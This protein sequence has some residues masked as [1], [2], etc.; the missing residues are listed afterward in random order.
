VKSG[1]QNAVADMLGKA[2]ERRGNVW[3]E[4]P[5]LAVIVLRGGRPALDIVPVDR[6]TWEQARPPRVL[7][8]IG[9]MIRIIEKHSRPR[10]WE[11]S[12]GV[13]FRTE[14]WGI[15]PEKMEPG[16]AERSEAVSDSW[17]HR[18]DRRADRVE[19]RL[20]TALDRDGWGYFIQ[21]LRGEEKASVTIYRPGDPDTRLEGAVPDALAR[22]LKAV[23]GES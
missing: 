22:V 11:D 2:L 21:Q 15:P 17:S 7:A 5:E 10:S 3:D 13:A 14:G 23:T 1:V 8:R 6:K 20:M 12:F 4:Q 19:M 18:I 9:E 16:T